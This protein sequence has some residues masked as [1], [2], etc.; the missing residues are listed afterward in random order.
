ME[1]DDFVLAMERAAG[2]FQ[3]YRA[4]LPVIP[5]AYTRTRL[6]DLPDFEV[7]A[8]HWAPGSISPIH[9][10]GLS[11]CWVLLMEGSLEVENF[12]RESAPDTNPVELRETGRLTLR[13]GD[14][15][16]RL[17]PSELHRVCNPSREG[18]YSLQLYARPIDEYRVIDEHTRHSRIVRAISDLEL[19]LQ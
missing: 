8:M 14:L 13:A 6:I 11:R 3:E 18:T 5:Y 10:H 12:E 9:D 2:R 4:R 17:G 15:D 1:N 16:H 7:V 19:P